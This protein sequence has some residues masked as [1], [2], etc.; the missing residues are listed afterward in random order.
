MQKFDDF[1]KVYQNVRWKATKK[2]CFEGVPSSLVLCAAHQ[3]SLKKKL[4]KNTKNVCFY[5][6]LSTSLIAVVSSQYERAKLGQY[7]AELNGMIY[8]L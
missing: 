1:H 8:L 7:P 3:C 4:K 2:K 5:R 6:A